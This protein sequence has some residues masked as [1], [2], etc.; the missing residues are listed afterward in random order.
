MKAVDA[1]IAAGWVA[2][3]LAPESSGDAIGYCPECAEP[4]PDNDAWP[5]A[6]DADAAPLPDVPFTPWRET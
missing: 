4:E 5:P 1:A 3:Q 2:V 6:Y